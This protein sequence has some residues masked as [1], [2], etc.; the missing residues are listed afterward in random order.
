M[1]RERYQT[2]LSDAEWEILS[3]HLPAPSAYGRPRKHHLREIVDAIYWV[4]RGGCGWRLLPHDF[5]SWKTVYHYFRQWRLDGAWER[6]HTALRERERCRLGRD[7]AP[8][9][10][11][12]T[13]SR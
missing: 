10:A 4:V 8:V 9:P 12:S 6:V 13:A 11:S 3:S 5:P 1:E 7:R 2:D